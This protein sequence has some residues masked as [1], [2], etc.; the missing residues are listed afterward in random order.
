MAKPISGRSNEGKSYKI[1]EKLQ[2][3]FRRRHVTDDQTGPMEESRVI[4]A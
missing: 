3:T 1:V 4:R 2:R